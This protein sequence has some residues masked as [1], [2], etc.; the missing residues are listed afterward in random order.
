M[1]DF[2]WTLTKALFAP[3]GLVWLALMALAWYSRRTGHR[4]LFWAHMALL[5]AYTVLGNAWV[6]GKTLAAFRSGFEGVDTFAS[7]KF[8]A[9]CVLGGGTS[10]APHGRAQLGQ[11]GDRVVLGARLLLTGQADKL[12][13]TGRSAMGRAPAEECAEIWGDLQI[14]A[15]RIVQLGGRNTEEEIQALAGAVKEHGWR[16]VGVITAA[17]HLPRVMQLAREQSLELVP[18]PAPLW[19]AQVR[20]SFREHLIPSATGFF[21]TQ[22]ALKELLGRAF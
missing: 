16:R 7:G 14:P 19:D 5:L 4:R 12:V 18:L 22:L 20:W 1:S 21:Q 9:V 6:G 2:F 3:V 15:E 17:W 13:C 8:D 11:G 10:T